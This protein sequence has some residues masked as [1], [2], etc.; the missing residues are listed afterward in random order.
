MPWAFFFPLQ[1]PSASHLLLPSVFMSILKHGSDLPSAFK[2]ICLYILRMA[3]RGLASNLIFSG[4]WWLE[5]KFSEEAT[6]AVK[7]RK[8]DYGFLFMNRWDV[9]N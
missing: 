2:K 6:C 4:S 1:F 9:V 7:I 3:E 5:L 8:T